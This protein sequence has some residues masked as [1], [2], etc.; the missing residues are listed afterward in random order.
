[1][2]H[3]NIFTKITLSITVL[4]FFSCNINNSSTS[5]KF[6]VK[7]TYSIKISD[8]LVSNKQ[9]LTGFYKL[10]QYNDSIFLY[11]FDWI[12]SVINFYHLPSG[13]FLK[14]L[15]LSKSNNLTL[16]KK[17]DILW[18][19]KDIVALFSDIDQIIALINFQG[20]IIQSFPI[21]DI[22]NTLPAY[23]GVSFGDR[24]M[25]FDRYNN[26]IIIQIAYID[27]VLTNK[28]DFNKY[29]SRPMF[30]KIEIT[31][32]RKYTKYVNVP[33]NYS[34]GN[35]YGNFNIFKC[36]GQNNCIVYSFAANDDV[37]IYQNDDT[38]AISAFAGSKMRPKF[39]PFDLSELQNFSYLRK[40]SIS[41]PFYQKIVYDEFN[42]LYLRVFKPSISYLNKDRKILKSDEIPWS[43]IILDNN[44]KIIG[45]VEM[46]PSNYS[47]KSIF[48]VDNGIIISN[49]HPDLEKLEYLSF[50]LLSIDY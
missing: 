42:N 7:E 8:S 13:T 47:F 9:A 23:M 37:F 16:N 50:T 18:I 1:M 3:V 28:E 27:A 17:V 35:Y 41:Q 48:P 26:Q 49:T 2:R 15:H 32:S 19:Q 25:I 36:I 11:Y 14:S 46:D 6:I 39:E 29:F 45:E 43:I 38:L 10:A 22:E 31:N 20:K 40:Y 12:N 30:Q 24:G 44:F 33:S 21:T 34:K 5:L 4:F